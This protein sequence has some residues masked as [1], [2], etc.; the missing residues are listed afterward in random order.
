MFLWRESELFFFF[1]FWL[2]NFF[3]PFISGFLE[4]PFFLLRCGFHFI[5][6]LIHW[7]SY[8]VNWCHSVFWKCPASISWNTVFACSFFPFFSGSDQI[9]G[10]P[11]HCVFFSVCCPLD[12]S[13]GLFSSLLM[14]YFAVF[15][16]LPSM[17]VKFFILITV[18]S[19]SRN[20]FGSFKNMLYH[21][22]WF[23]VNIFKFVIYLHM[24]NM[25]F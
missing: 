6:L 15:S 9:Y 11:H 18:F 1:F 7:H 12:N 24:A 20:L 23:P 2:L 21:F 25:L 14:L 19:L 22:F 5:Y 4:F 13:S 3:S 8:Y 16:L 10:R 17:S